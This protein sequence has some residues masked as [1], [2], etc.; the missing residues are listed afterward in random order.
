M[1]WVLFFFDSEFILI[2]ISL[3]CH[4]FFPDIVIFVFLMFAL[5]PCPI[6]FFCFWLNGPLF[7]EIAD[8]FV[9]HLDFVDFHSVLYQGMQYGMI[10]NLEAEHYTFV[11][12]CL[13]SQSFPKPEREF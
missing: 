9:S 2:K 1:F 3:V 8:F 4:T 11:A 10:L 13:C 7:V 6:V 5:T 12:G